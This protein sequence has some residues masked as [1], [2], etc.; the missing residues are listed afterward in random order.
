MGLYRIP[1]LGSLQF[2][3]NPLAGFKAPTSNENGKMA[4]SGLIQMFVTC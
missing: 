2:S 1:L 3:T 4:R